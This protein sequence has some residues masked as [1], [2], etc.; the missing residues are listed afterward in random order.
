MEMLS[1]MNNESE[2][3][4]DTAQEETE[5][6]TESSV[7]GEDLQQIHTDLQVICGF[8]VVFLIIVLCDY[9]YKFFKIFF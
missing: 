3:E 1:E 9:I 6:V 5:T 7:Y 8:I 4:S 2:P